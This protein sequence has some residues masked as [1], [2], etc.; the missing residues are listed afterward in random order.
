MSAKRPDLDAL[1]A[2][3]QLREA[4]LEGADLAGADLSRIALE[5][6]SLK[7]ANLRGA[8]L[9]GADL[10][11]VDLSEADLE[12]ADLRGATLEQTELDRAILHDVDARGATLR[13]CGLGGVKGR[14]V[15][16]AG[17][18][19][20]KLS[21]VGATLEGMVL[22][23]AGLD[24]VGFLDGELM[25]V[26]WVGARVT[27]C[28]ITGTTLQD[29]DLTGATVEALELRRC[30]LRGSTA[31]GLLLR[32]CRLRELEIED[33]NLPG[34][35]VEACR[36]LGRTGEAAL[37]A[38]GATI[39]L[40]PGQRAYRAL[41]ANRP[42][43]IALLVGLIL[44]AIAVV[45]LLRSPT[46]WPTALLISRFEQAEARN[47]A[48]RCDPL[49]DLGGVLAERD[50]VPAA[51]KRSFV[52][53][54]AECE[55]QQGHP[56][57]AEALL[58]RQVELATEDR[59][60][61][62]TSLDVLGRFL[63]ERGEL[64]AADTV[65]EQMSAL[66][67]L[68]HERLEV[69]RFQA[70]LLSARGHEATPCH[71]D[72]IPAEPD[73]WRSLQLTTADT[74]EAL[75]ELAEHHL[76]GTPR[77][78]YFLGEWS[79]A[80]TLLAAIGE[81]F[82]EEQAWQ[83]AKAAVDKLVAAE[84]ADLASE[85]VDQLRGEGSLDS[86]TALDL[87]RTQ[88]SLLSRQGLDEASKALLDEAQPPEGPEL[89][90]ELELLR[91]EVA[92]DAGN[93]ERALALLGAAKPPAD[94]PFD[95]LSRHGWLL[96]EARL[97]SGDET[98]AVDALVPLLH[99]VPDKEQAQGLLQ[100]LAGWMNRLDDPSRL[101]ALLSDVDNPMLAKA[102]QGQELAL[103]ALR[104]RARHGDL[105]ADDPALL[106]VLERGT[107]DQVRQAAG[108]LL[109]VARQQG[110]REQ[111]IDTL[112]PRAR[113]LSDTRSREELGLMLADAAMAAGMPERATE[114]VQTLGLASSD[115]TD[116]RSRALGLGVTAALR[117]GDLDRALA[118]FRQALAGDEDMADWV[119]RDLGRRVLDSLQSAGRWEEAL[120]LARLLLAQDPEAEQENRREVMAC[121]IAMGQEDQLAVEI[122][123][124]ADAG[125]ACQAYTL[126]SRAWLD[127]GR[128]AAGL[129][130][131]RQACL[132]DEAEPAHR[133]AAAATLG[134]ANQPRAAL[135]L[136]ESIDTATLDTDLRV[137][138][139]REHAAWLA[140][141]SARP[142]AVVLLDQGYHEVQGAQACER[143][144]DALIG[145]R[146]SLG[147]H[148][149]V[150]AAY[151]RF[152]EDHPTHELQNL[153]RHAAETL[154]RGGQDQAVVALGGDPSWE[155]LIQET[156]ARARFQAL[157]EL[158][159]WDQA[160]TW[161]DSAA[162]GQT[163]P[164]RL[165]ELLQRARTLADRSQQQERFLGFLDS[166][167]PQL[168]ATSKASSQARLFRAR[169][170]VAADRGAEAL[171]GLDALLAQEIPS[172]LR[173]DVLRS[174]GQVLGSQLEPSAVQLRLT[175]LGTAGVTG[176]ELRLV[177]QVAARQLLE[178]GEPAAAFSTL[179]PLAG[180]TLEAD[181]ATRLH[182]VLVRAA[183]ASGQLDAAMAV[184]ERFPSASGSCQAWLLL[185]QNLP[186]D[187]PQAEQAREGA[188]TACQPSDV[189]VDQALVLAGALAKPQ[190][191]QALSFLDA[192]R[193]VPGL[194]ALDRARLDV[195]RAEVLA[196]QGRPDQ[197]R[198]TLQGILDTT[199]EPQIATRACVQLVRLERQGGDPDRAT[200]AAEPCLARVA[201]SVPAT[202]ELLLELVA[203]LGAMEAYDQ[204]SSWQQRLVEALP[205]PTEDRGY[206]L[207]HLALLR[208]QAGG[209]APTPA[210]ARWLE[211]V[212]EAQ[213]L[214]K[215]DTHLHSELTSLELAW[216]VLQ[217]YGEPTG[218]TA[219]LDQAVARNDN[220]SSLLNGVAA[221]LD[222]WKA[223]DA[224]RA[225]R[226][227]RE[228]RYPG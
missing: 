115:S 129:E 162:Q 75:N 179:D 177:R 173:S 182:E 38:A 195:Q 169:A 10:V 127:V 186:S 36:G 93:T 124:A 106:A 98:G 167:E 77:E 101:A 3:S 168:P 148:E 184:P 188:L 146:G 79:R 145:Q 11:Q 40:P 2:G 29:C 223:V 142:A 170:L 130:E 18:S 228:R 165:E 46:L 86:F 204:A 154:I 160:W 220:G 53:R 52:R 155:K 107:V 158:R 120:E 14:N 139:L 121:L 39:T 68:P 216:K 103:T 23:G 215:P 84:R 37:E 44:L 22:D 219:L 151:R 74:L 201:S 49:L 82:D 187:R 105:S 85:L 1:R 4:N 116:T 13:Q 17:A 164:E 174:Y 100:E 159:E 172:E 27:D 26:S 203:T 221:R 135:A 59:D 80:A 143:I 55:L 57:R 62:R 110:S 99:A 6:V 156:A 214:A 207:L 132:L 196:T 217:I 43:Q 140:A 227:E 109:D 126:V 224:A 111:A 119:R 113:K 41:L 138:V 65:A 112:L 97:R 176:A 64:E 153:W 78:L 208:I 149:G 191:D 81:E 15:L 133:L 50:A 212:A 70:T 31:R 19:L 206:A 92:I 33:T 128:P 225:V 34:S 95:R 76:E 30:K 185:L 35:V 102:G 91:A 83:H 175:E 131:L 161:L 16:L 61:H 123:A 42:L 144:T 54:M 150:V 152:A 125:T 192:A 66:A 7:A 63:V 226:T 88:V 20:S 157:L 28:A 32:R 51:R 21:V 24:D 8:R 166:I 180:Q 190:A 211:L 72:D 45:V 12:G 90:L 147:D 108:L 198:A 210:D 67:D 89:A 25:G 60:E 118:S 189:T 58:R 181:E 9:C 193:Q 202:K 163:S 48:G 122:R 200:A 71:P 87:L 5:R 194:L 114:I 171:A 218:L 47:D 136:V 94:A 183:V 197:A 69:L 199:E 117:D 56:E 134:Q 96:A 209:G 137:Q 222:A 205:E 104:A 213:T 73:P 178:R 141:T